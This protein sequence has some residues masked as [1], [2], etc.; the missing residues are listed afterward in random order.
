MKLAIHG[1]KP[2]R[3]VPFPAYI[4]IGEEEKRAV[5]EVLESKVLSGFLGTW[6]PQFYGGERVKKLE[7]EWSAYFGVKHAVSVNSATSG[8]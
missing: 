8:L 6:S 3:S 2:V 7:A 1:G 5:L 4:T